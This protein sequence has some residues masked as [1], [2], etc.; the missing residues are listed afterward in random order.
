M[1]KAVST[2]ELVIEF[3][4]CNERYKQRYP[5]IPVD[6]AWHC[7]GIQ[8]E[9]LD[10]FKEWT[11]NH[12]SGNAIDAPTVD[13]DK[14]L[15]EPAV[16]LPIWAEAMRAAPNELIRSALFNAKNR[17]NKRE[18]LKN[19][20]IYVVGDGEMRYTGEELRQDDETVWMQILHLARLQPLA[21][22]VEFKRSE[23]LKALGWPTSAYYY[24]R[25]DETI[26]RLSAT[27]LSIASKRLHK[28]VGVSLIRKYDDTE[29]LV[30]IWL[31]PEIKTLFEGQHYTLNEWKQ[32]LALPSG[33]ASWLHAYFASHAKPYPVKLETIA[34]GAGVKFERLRALRAKVEE[35][36][37]GLVDVGFL[38]S[39]EIKNGLVH[40][41]RE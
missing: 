28:L 2:K 26:K 33:I 13:M 8:S 32:R 24:R 16:Q 12:Q 9:F 10:E 17:N 41:E 34:E 15:M 37:Q 7:A 29:D 23:F 22:W 18:Y 1:K 21:T 6:K 3:L 19:A 25:L 4:S 38:K 36:L 14:S 27:N 30:K 31:E 20:P 5:N 40:V 11:N 39:Y 35:A